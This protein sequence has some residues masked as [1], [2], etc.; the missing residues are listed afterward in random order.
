M[1]KNNFLLAII[2]LALVLVSCQPETEI[3]T[4]VVDFEDV[5]LVDSIWNG[6][7]LKAGFTINDVTFKNSYDSASYGGFT[8]YFWS[9]FACSAKKDTQT[10]GYFNQYSVMAGSGAL[11]SKQFALAYDS[12]SVICPANANGNLK[13]S[14]V[15]ITNS[16]Y[17]YLDML[18]G[19]DYSKKFA[20]GD[21]FKVIITGY[22]NNVKQSTVEYYLADFRDGKTVLSKTWDKIDLSSLG[23]VDRLSFTFDSSDKTGGWMN[24][25]AYACI[26]NITFEQ[27]I[28]E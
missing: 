5:A 10:G 28:K 15:M 2:S 8:M 23:S 21:W 7:D 24:T 12:A 17:A 25:P 16:T 4:T 13:I 11:G 20:S 6:S 26:D 9:G 22:L 19:S 18:N 1:K 3:K 27:E 14:S